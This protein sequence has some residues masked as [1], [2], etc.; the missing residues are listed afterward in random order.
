MLLY[1]YC[2]NSTFFKI[3][4]NHQIW[5]SDISRSNDYNEM[6]LF[7]PGIFRKIEN[8]YKTNPF[9][10]IYKKKTGLVALQLLLHE[11]YETIG[12]ARDQGILT[13]YVV[14]FSREKD[15]LSQWRGYA[16]NGKGC[17]VGF[18]LE[19]LERYCSRSSGVITIRKVEYIN[20]QTLDKVLQEKAEELVPHFITLRND[21][22]QL[23]AYGDLSEEE[24][25]AVMQLLAFGLFENFLFDSLQ[26]KWDDYE[27][28]AEWRMFFK[29][30]TKNARHLFGDE[31]D[32]PERQERACKGY[33]TQHNKI[34]FFARDDCIVPYFPVDLEDISSEPIKDVYLGPKNNSHI[35]DV[36]LL[37]AREKLGEP[38]IQD[39][40]ISYR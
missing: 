10:F 26:Y 31:K 14:C 29:Q 11:V 27:E 15:L 4:S 35:Q 40:R 32:L 21:A 5:M 6:R 13:S 2:S 22:K 37:F 39:S 36:K 38:N 25:D 18:S 19:E 1:H 17:A 7:I 28:E 9:E 20:E 33:F 23:F 34:Q 12:R 30:I 24:P 8:V 16:D 3:V